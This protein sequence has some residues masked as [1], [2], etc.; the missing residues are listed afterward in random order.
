[1]GLNGKLSMVKCKVCSFIEKINKLIV[2]KFDGLQKYDAWQKAT[3]AK[4]DVKVGEY[5]MSLNSQH[6]K[7]EWQ[8]VIMHAK[9]FMIDHANVSLLIKNKLKFW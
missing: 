8:F 5:F 1:M 2:L 3:I 9:G 7:N 6:V 4:L